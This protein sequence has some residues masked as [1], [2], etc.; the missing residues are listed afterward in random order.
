M[1][2][3][4]THTFCKNA[5]SMQPFSSSSLHGLLK[6]DISIK[7]QKNSSLPASLNRH[8]MQNSSVSS[9]NVYRNCQH[10][11]WTLGARLQLSQGKV[12]WHPIALVG[13][14]KIWLS[15]CCSA[16]HNGQHCVSLWKLF[17]IGGPFLKALSAWTI[18]QF[19]Q[20]QLSRKRKS[21]FPPTSPPLLLRFSDWE[22]F[23]LG[24]SQPT[25]MVLHV[26]L[27][28]EAF[29]A[30]RTTVLVVASVGALMFH[31]MS[32]PAEGL[33][34]VL[35]LVNLHPWTRTEKKSFL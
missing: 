25:F 13:V 19:C 33:V 18:F 14:A 28:S 15:R 32:S 4:Q 9:L 21:H 34:T 6:Q 23:V 20:G 11:A 31:H 27:A 17:F 3:F 12:G 29:A 26:L 24:Q 8:K 10:G 1:S 35:A 7:E 22:F 2:V 30:S 16:N 5:T